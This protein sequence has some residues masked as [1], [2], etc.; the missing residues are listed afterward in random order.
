VSPATRWLVYACRTDFTADVV[1]I[2]A[3]RG[4]EVAVLVDNLDEDL[5]PAAR[6]GATDRPVIRPADLTAALRGH[7]AVIP[8]ITPGFRHRVVSEARAAGIGVFPPLIDPTSVLAPSS[9]VGEGTVVNA[10]AVFGGEVSIGRFVHVN[11][12][13]SVGHHSV[14]HDFSTLGP[15]C[16]LAGRVE[17]RSGAFIGAGAVCAPKVRIGA[18]AVVGAGAVVVRDVPP[19]AVV[20]GNPATVIRQGDLGYGG[21]SVPT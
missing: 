17:V 13:A 19:G 5:E 21:A 16:V 6:A 4:D 11:R 15:G 3:R 12:S 9:T 20:V 8:L 14:L 2:I 18:N 1:A 10:A 7:P